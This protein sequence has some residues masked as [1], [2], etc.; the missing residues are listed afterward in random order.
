[1]Y[2]WV[3]RLAD[4]RN[5]L[6]VDVR[7]RGNTARS[8]NPRWLTPRPIPFPGEGGNLDNVACVRLQSAHVETR[9]VTR[10]G[11]KPQW[12][13]VVLRVLKFKKANQYCVEIC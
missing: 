3:S 13:G 8:F 4:V 10:V 9:D 1:M 5:S 6:E 2:Y 11:V 7:P 12:H